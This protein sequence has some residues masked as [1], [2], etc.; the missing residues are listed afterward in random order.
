LDVFIWAML[1]LIIYKLYKVDEKLSHL[2]DK[3]IEQQMEK[4]IE[5]LDSSIREKFGIESK[6]FNEGKIGQK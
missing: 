2:Y 3:S 5:L 6:E 1:C 4:E